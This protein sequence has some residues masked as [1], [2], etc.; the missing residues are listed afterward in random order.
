METYEQTGNVFTMIADFHRAVRKHYEKLTD[1][2]E[3]KRVRL[4]LDYLSRHERRF[5]EGLAQYTG[6]EQRKV[7]DTWYQYIPDD[8]KLE[9]GEIDLTP[10]MSVDEVVKLA[11]QIKRL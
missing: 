8:L 2:A 4:L 11:G 6:Q 1:E 9:P 10:D 3:K 7:L 5:E